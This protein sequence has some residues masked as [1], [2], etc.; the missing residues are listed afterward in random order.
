MARDR[1]DANSLVDLRA[2]NHVGYELA[3]AILFKASLSANVSSDNSRT[4]CRNLIFSASRTERRLI[5]RHSGSASPCLCNFRSDAFE[6]GVL[7]FN[8][9]T[10]FII[11][12]T[13]FDSTTN[14]PLIPHLPTTDE[15]SN[16]RI[17]AD[18]Y[19]APC[20]MGHTRKEY[21]LCPALTLLTLNLRLDGHLN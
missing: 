12:P 11:T 14:T 15:R 2:C 6:S 3:R 1:F 5:G 19:A 18:L 17:I 21:S 8:T 20:D 10:G 9:D 7:V 4:A 16:V 13:L